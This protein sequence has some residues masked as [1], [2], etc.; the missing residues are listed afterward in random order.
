MF[1]TQVAVSTP[2]DNSTNGWVANNVQAAIEEAPIHLRAVKVSVSGTYTFTG[3]AALIPGL[4]TTPVAGIYKLDASGDSTVASAG[5]TLT[6]GLYIGGTLMT[7]SARTIGPFDGGALSATTGRGVW[8][9]NDLI[10]VTGAQAVEIRGSTSTTG[11]GT[12]NN[13]GTMILLRIT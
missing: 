8:A 5:A 6:F 10:T 1:V 13:T 4:T 7:D 12:V 3:A 9:I 11:A 2:F